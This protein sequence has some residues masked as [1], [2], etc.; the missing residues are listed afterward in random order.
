MDWWKRTPYGADS[1]VGQVL[2]DALGYSTFGTSAHDF[3]TKFTLDEVLVNHAYNI[4]GGLAIWVNQAPPHGAFTPTPFDGNSV[5]TPQFWTAPAFPYASVATLDSIVQTMTGLGYMVGVDVTIPVWYSGAG[6]YGPGALKAAINISYPL[7]GK[8]SPASL[9]M[10][11]LTR[12]R[13]YDMT[14]DSSN[15]GVIM[16]E[17]GVTGSMTIVENVNPLRGAPLSG[18]GPLPWPI[19]E[20]VSSFSGTLTGRSLTGGHG[21]TSMLEFLAQSESYMASFPIF[22]GTARMP[23][24]GPDPPFGAAVAG[25]FGIGDETMVW[26][27]PGFDNNFPKGLNQLMRIVSWQ[28][29]VPAGGD[30][31]VDI[32]LNIPPAA[33]PPTAP[34]FP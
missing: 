27:P 12:A 9:L 1:I 31:T 13:Q 34:V 33:S 19:L 10:V 24:F 3:A 25:G 26:L 6:P 5:I 17:T 20:Q 14:E 11:D 30:Q 21:I 16:Y 23:L 32:T 22:S 29:N 18:G 7:A 2:K 4:L 8:L 15:Q 28:A